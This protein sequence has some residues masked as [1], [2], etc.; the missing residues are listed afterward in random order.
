MLC[1]SDGSSYELNGDWDYNIQRITHITFYHVILVSNNHAYTSLGLF[2]SCFFCSVTQYQRSPY[3]WVECFK[4]VRCSL[5]ISLCSCRSIEPLPFRNLQWYLET[6]CP[7]MI[8]RLNL[9]PDGGLC[10]QTMSVRTMRGGWCE[11]CTL[12]CHDYMNTG[13]A[14]RRNAECYMYLLLC[15]LYRCINVNLL[16]FIK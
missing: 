14:G 11:T 4:M 3:L 6:N 15:T 16:E 1:W 13:S 2:V 9:A 10:G 7:M 12:F 5:T 8:T